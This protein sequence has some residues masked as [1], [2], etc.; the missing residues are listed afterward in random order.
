MTEYYKVTALK[1]IV[2][3]AT[4]EASPPE[5]IL[6]TLPSSARPGSFSFF[7]LETFPLKEG[8]SREHVSIIHWVSQSGESIRLDI[9]PHPEEIGGQAQGG[10]LILIQREY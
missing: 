8:E 7:A 5:S 1:D 3:S 9:L 4:V 2:V 10:E 6:K